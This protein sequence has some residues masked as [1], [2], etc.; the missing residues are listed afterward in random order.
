MSWTMIDEDSDIIYVRAII[1]T[2]MHADEVRELITA[3][4]KRL[5]KEPTDVRPT[6]DV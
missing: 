4:E 6:P 5:P 3:L 2:K 1:D